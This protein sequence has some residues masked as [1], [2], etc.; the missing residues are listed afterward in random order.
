MQSVDSLLGD[1]VRLGLGETRLSVLSELLV[2]LAYGLGGFGAT[3][4]QLRRTDGSLTGNLSLDHLE[5]FPEQ[6]RLF[7]LA[8]GFSDASYRCAYHDLPLDRATGQAVLKGLHE[9]PDARVSRMVDHESAFARR[10]D[11]GSILAVRARFP[12]GSFGALTLYRREPGPFDEKTRRAMVF[13]GEHVAYLYFGVRDRVAYQLVNEVTAIVIDTAASREEVNGQL[14]RVCELTSKA[15]GCLETS[16]L[17]EDRTLEPDLFQVSATT[18]APLLRKEHY[19]LGDRGLTAAVI[20]QKMPLFILNTL[21]PPGSVIAS[22]GWQR[23]EGLEEV[24]RQLSKVEE[25][26]DTPPIAFAAVPMVVD[27]RVV[28]VLRCSVCP[29]APYF[30]AEREIA[31]MGILAGRVASFWARWMRWRELQAGGDAWKRFAEAL[32]GLNP[33]RQELGPQ[34]RTTRLKERSRRSYYLEALRVIKASCP[35]VDAVEFALADPER[36]LIAPMAW[37]GKEWDRLAS[38]KGGGVVLPLIS[39]ESNAWAY[40]FHKQEVTF[41]AD[42]AKPQIPY[43]NVIP[44]TK[45]VLFAPVVA[46]GQSIGVLGIRTWSRFRDPKQARNMVQVVAMV[47][48]SYHQLS[49]L[50]SGQSQVYQDLEHQLRGPIAQA[51]KRI[52]A[53]LEEER[54]DSTPLLEGRHPYLNAVGGLLGKVRRVLG[55]IRLFEEL[56]KGN[57][58]VPRKESVP[59]KEVA[60]MLRESAADNRALWQY[61][62]IGTRVNMESF[63]AIRTPISIDVSLFEQA[64]NNVIDNAGKYGQQGTLIEIEG[65]VDESK[66]LRVIVRNQAAVVIRRDDLAHIGT[67]GYRA[68]AAQRLTAEGIGS[69]LYLVKLI[70]ESH[71]GALIVSE[72]DPMGITEIAMTFPLGS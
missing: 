14:G 55:N 34:M 24:V 22:T 43:V 27:E 11:P 40:V 26:E 42:T 29:D 66:Q 21:E 48:A 69:G 52:W 39:P 25:G 49:E 1:L 31:L 20:Q 7:V 23:R 36:K 6:G 37:L 30:L 60:K 19:R 65:H 71:G 53:V 72:T 16:I 57:R 28:G 46:D 56:A 50:L 59:M 4:W 58:I 10:A 3:L 32:N 62:R 5:Q 41:I 54:T 15:L 9:E 8:H 64:A 18:C 45:Q 38:G 68:E 51:H 61:K 33:Q 2:R 70:A 17:L 44:L 47:M 13:L 63:E 12:D 67:R 35:E